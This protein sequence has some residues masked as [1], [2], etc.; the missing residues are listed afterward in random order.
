MATLPPGAR[1]REYREDGDRREPGRKGLTR[2]RPPRIRVDV[3]L[4][5]VDP[6]AVDDEATKRQGKGT[7]SL[8]NE[9]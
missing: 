6:Q 8:Y 5:L 9:E 3:Y 7:E 4:P 2:C 1:I